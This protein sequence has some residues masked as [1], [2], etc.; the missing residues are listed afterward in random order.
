MPNE[1]YLAYFGSDSQHG[2]SDGLV[3]HERSGW[4]DG[5][6]PARLTGVTDGTLGYDVSSL[7][8]KT[9]TWEAALKGLNGL[10]YGSRA[11]TDSQRILE[12]FDVANAVFSQI[13][14]SVINEHDSRTLIYDGGSADPNEPLKIHLSEAPSPLPGLLHQHVLNNPHRAQ[15]PI[16][17]SYYISEFAQGEFGKPLA[18]TVPPN[19]SSPIAGLL[20]GN[21]RNEITYAHEV[22]HFLLGSSDVEG[23]EYRHEDD[24]SGNHS[25][26]NRNLMEA[27]ADRPI[28]SGINVRK[29]P[30]WNS[31]IASYGK[32]TGTLDMYGR[33][34]DEVYLDLDSDR[35]FDVGETK[36]SQEQ[37]MHL[38]TY[39]ANQ[40]QNSAFAERADLYWVE[41]SYL[42][43]GLDRAD[44]RKGADTLVWGLG[45]LKVP[46]SNSDA[47]HS[48]WS[49]T[50]LPLPITRLNSASFNYVDIVS[51]VAAMEI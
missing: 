32:V 26:E 50:A 41:D 19:G 33:L 25:T 40:P 27:S 12:D 11:A 38:S 16:I 42:L 17:N 5:R 15:S 8:V 36:I 2:T 7:T 28:G 48:L 45:S 30:H 18:I 49:P 39:I 44:L 46:P 21:E 9:H 34:S 51:N 23:V 29:H 6:H 13:G 31:A 14:V 4:T 10:E 20:I 35:K 3:G 37:A 22:G 47:D 43:E 1:G 24:P